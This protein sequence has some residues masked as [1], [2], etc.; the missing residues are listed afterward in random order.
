M[1]SRAHGCDLGWIGEMPLGLRPTR[2][3][4]Q[5]DSAQYA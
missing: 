5:A 1:V 3:N 2:R 4:G